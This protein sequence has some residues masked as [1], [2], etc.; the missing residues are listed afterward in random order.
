MGGRG[1][2]K[3]QKR[4][5]ALLHLLSLSGGGRGGGQ[6]GEVHKCKSALCTFALLH[7]SSLWGEVGGGE[8]WEVQKCK[9]ALL[10]F[11]TCHPCRFFGPA[12]ICRCLGSWRPRW[13]QKPSQN[14]GSDAPHL[15]AWFLG[16]PGLPG[17]GKSATSGRPKNHVSTT[18]TWDGSGNVPRRPATNLLPA[19]S[20]VFGADHQCSVQ[21]MVSPIAV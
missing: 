14:V 7:L 15:L 11:C 17:P 19:R 8:G 3:V 12:R 2:A 16:P 5:F 10:H 20:S 1:R 18:R 4:T 6:G 9:S 21:E 13:P